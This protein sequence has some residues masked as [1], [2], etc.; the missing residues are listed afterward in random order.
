MRVFV[1][2]WQ[3]RINLMKIL[4]SLRWF[5]H[6]EMLFNGTFILASHDQETTNFAWWARNA[7]LSICPVNYLELM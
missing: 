3:L 6:V 4:Y 7:D 5:Y 2:G 1:H